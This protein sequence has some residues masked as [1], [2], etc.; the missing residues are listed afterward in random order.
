MLPCTLTCTLGHRP[1]AFVG[2]EQFPPEVPACGCVCCRPEAMLEAAPPPPRGPGSAVQW[3]VLLLE[4][5]SDSEACALSL[6]PAS[7]VAP[8]APGQPAIMETPGVLLMSLGCRR[9]DW[10]KVTWRASGRANPALP[11]LGVEKCA[12]L[13]RS[14][15]DARVV[16]GQRREEGTP[17][18]GLAGCLGR[19]G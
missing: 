18:C 5:L 9:G 8:C 15:V 2:E 19:W 10:P 16:V 12:Q 3:R 11:W 17:L 6:S 13:G 4:T 7:P 1:E 14:V